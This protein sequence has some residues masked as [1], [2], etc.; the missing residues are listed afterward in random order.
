[1]KRRLIGSALLVVLFGILTAQGQ[2]KDEDYANVLGRLNVW[3]TREVMRNE[4][5]RGT[6]PEFMK[7]RFERHADFDRVVFDLKGDI[8]SY[9]ITYSK[10]PF[11]SEAGD[12]EIKVRGKAFVEISLYP[13]TSSNENIEANEKA[14]RQPQQLKMLT[15]KDVKTVEWFEG[16]LRYVFGLSKRTPYRVQ[17]FSNPL[18]VVVDFKH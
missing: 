4:P 3:T 13:V 7:L 1:M 11:Q 8:A 14:A 9:Y 16:E 15:I 12:R 18:R 2:A 6:R 5:K 10:P 17:V